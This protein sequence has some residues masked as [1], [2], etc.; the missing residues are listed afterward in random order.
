MDIK[1]IKGDL[2]TTPHKVILH[3]ANNMGVMGSGV[4]KHIRELYPD[5]YKT[6]KKIHDTVG[7]EGGTFHAVNSNGKI[8]INAITQNNYGR[9]GRR[10]VNYEWM[11][12]IFE[13]VDAWC[14]VNCM[15]HVAM[16]MVG[17]TLGGGNWR[18][19]ERLIEETA[20][21]YQPVVYVL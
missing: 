2:F 4:A 6:Y 18:I 3:G 17:S 14:E 13:N 11:Y 15:D 7:L 16:P 20:T 19:I 12:Q 21:K 10:F 8:I 5:A 9:T 1:Y